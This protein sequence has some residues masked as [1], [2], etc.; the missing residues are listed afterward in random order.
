MASFLSLLQ[1]NGWTTCLDKKSVMLWYG[2]SDFDG[3]IC[4]W[5]KSISKLLELPWI[6]VDIYQPITEYINHV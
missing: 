2:K 6:S 1:E 3:E 4:Y 5:N